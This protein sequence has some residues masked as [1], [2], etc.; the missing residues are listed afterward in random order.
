MFFLFFS[1]F[2]EMGTVLELMRSA[3]TMKKTEFPD[4]VLDDFSGV[5]FK[6]L[7]RGVN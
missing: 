4:S 7:M 2:R 1:W 6:W 5:I 3:I